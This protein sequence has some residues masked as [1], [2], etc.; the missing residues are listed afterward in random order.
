[1]CKYLTAFPVLLL[2]FVSTAAASPDAPSARRVAV[3]LELVLAVDTSASI[4]DTEYRLQ[5]EG[6]A[7]AFRDPAVTAAIESFGG[8]G[9]AVSM[10]QWSTSASR[11]T[12]WAHIV[13]ARGAFDYAA[14]IERIK[15]PSRWRMGVM[16]A[17]GTALALSRSEIASNAYI[18]RRRSI[19]VSGDGKKNSGLLLWLERERTTSAGITINGLAIEA[20]E[21]FL[22]D[23][24]NDK[25]IGGSGAFALAAT[26]FDDFARAFRQKLL[27]EIRTPLSF[28]QNP[29]PYRSFA[30]RSRQAAPTH[31]LGAPTSARSRRHRYR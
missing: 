31:R 19:D 27:Q 1:M 2:L 28:R 7:R 5:M 26:G 25:V 29:L 18:G 24:Y 21:R 23:Y 6:I 10:I 12:P 13:D 17:I 9:I 15:R 4:S 8:T 3:E 30:K 14:Q 20:Q 16:T 11:V 22:L